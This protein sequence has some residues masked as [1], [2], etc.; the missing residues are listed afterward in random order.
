[1][2][3]QRRSFR[4]SAAVTMAGPLGFAQ[5]SRTSEARTL[6]FVQVDVFTTRALEGNP[7]MVFPKAE[8]LSDETMLAIARELNHSETTFIQPS[9]GKGDAV[10]RI[11]STSAELPFAGHPTLGTAFVLA[12]SHPGKTPLQ[13]EEKVDRGT[14]FEM[15]QNDPT[16]GPKYEDK[17]ALA[18]SLMLP[19][20]EFD[21]RYTPQVVSTGTPFLI[22][23]LR[24][25]SSLERLSA[26]GRLS[27]EDRERMGTG[28]V[29]YIVTGDQEI[30]ARLPG[31][32]E[33]PATGSAAG[34][35][36]SYLVQYGRQKP[37]A[38]FT[39]HQGRFV[40][41][42]SLIYAAAALTGGRVHNVRVGGYVVE[43]MRGSMLL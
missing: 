19:A 16:F 36:A 23:P 30:E 6:D 11:F 40:N 25:K 18:K 33:D 39:I 8:G 2:T 20:G 27:S 24:A 15:T 22:V 4:L 9:R 10:V 32:S 21:S 1:M 12:Q 35:A 31:R 34:C 42:P 13:L 41:R 17:G 43:V 3:M 26:D 5:T 14:Y 37:D 28:A 7:L 29:Y 38:Q